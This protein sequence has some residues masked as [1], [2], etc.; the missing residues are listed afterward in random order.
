MKKKKPNRFSLDNGQIHIV[1][2][3][4]APV[5]LTK[6]ISLTEDEKKKLYLLENSAIKLKCYVCDLYVEQS[7]VT[8]KINEAINALEKAQNDFLEAAKNIATSYGI[9]VNDPNKGKW[10]L[11]TTSMKFTKID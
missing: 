9:D 8:Q 2:E 10:N 6:S 4:K 11:D 1:P 7:K 5:D 3:P